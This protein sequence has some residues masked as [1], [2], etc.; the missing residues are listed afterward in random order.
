MKEKREPTATNGVLME[1]T[2]TAPCDDGDDHDYAKQ[3][4][5]T[6]LEGGS[7]CP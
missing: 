2:R 7:R 3:N 5:L 4:S 1:M 6:R